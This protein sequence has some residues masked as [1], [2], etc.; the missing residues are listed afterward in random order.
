MV[1]MMSW[2]VTE[3]LPARRK[4]ANGGTQERQRQRMGRGPPSAWAKPVLQQRTWLSTVQNG[5]AIAA[6][7]GSAG[8]LAWHNGLDQAWDLMNLL[9]SVPAGV[10][11]KASLPPPAGGSSEAPRTSLPSGPPPRPVPHALFLLSRNIFDIAKDERA[12]P[13]PSPKAPPVPKPSPPLPPPPA[14]PLGAGLTLLGTLTEGEGGLAVIHSKKTRGTAIFGVGDHIDGKKVLRIERKR[15]L[16]TQGGRKEY[17][18]L[19]R[20]LTPRRGARGTAPRLASAPPPRP[21]PTAP[22]ASTYHP[23]RTAPP[24][25]STSHNQQSVNRAEVLR[26]FGNPAKFL[27]QVT[28]EPYYEQ[29]K[30]KGY[31]IKK[32]K[33]NSYAQKLGLKEGDILE[34][35]N[36][37]LI[38]TIQKALRLI[39]LIH[40]APGLSVTV[41][42]GLERK[43]MQY[44]FS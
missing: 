25:V 8:Y 21:V 2:A 14:P 33:P 4:A 7:L 43:K 13:P 32:V 31:Y 20:T 41:R 6:L 12:P 27:S 15:V 18:L 42:R 22:P 39:G 11:A 26:E 28:A 40:R 3:I 1:V 30:F 23:G 10:E 38:D 44:T 17:I 34:T 24:A 37:Q 5:V 9:L 19:A 29:M 16:L 35:V 36:G